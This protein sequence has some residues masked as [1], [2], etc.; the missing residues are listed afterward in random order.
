MADYT[1]TP[2]ADLAA[3]RVA[4]ETIAAPSIGPTTTLGS[5]TFTWSEMIDMIQELHKVNRGGAED[6]LFHIE[7]IDFYTRLEAEMAA[8]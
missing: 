4:L 3:A 8:V 1:A 7:L 6:Q 5:S 2:V